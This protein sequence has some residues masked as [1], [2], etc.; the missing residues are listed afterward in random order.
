MDNCLKP[1]RRLK[2]PTRKAVAVRTVRYTIAVCSIC[3]R[4][5]A[6]SENF[7]A[8]MNDIFGKVFCARCWENKKP[9]RATE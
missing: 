7:A 4:I 9:G 5:A 1:R 3:R 2:R 6:P 8:M